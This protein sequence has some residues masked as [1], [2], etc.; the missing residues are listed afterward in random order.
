MAHPRGNCAEN[1]NA[2]L[3]P[4]AE[5]CAN[6]IM[7]STSTFVAVGNNNATATIT[8][9]SP[10]PSHEGNPES[11]T[12]RKRSP[13]KNQQSATATPIAS[14]LR[15]ISLSPTRII[16]N[17]NEQFEIKVCIE[18]CH[19]L[20]QYSLSRVTFDCDG[21]GLKRNTW[22]SYR[23]MNAVVQSEMLSKGLVLERPMMHTFRIQSSMLELVRYFN[24]K[25]NSILRVHL[26]TE[27]EVLGTSSIDLR[28]VISSEHAFHDDGNGFEG[29]MVQNDYTFN[30]RHANAT[31]VEGDGSASPLCAPRIAVRLCIDR[32]STIRDSGLNSDR[33]EMI[34]NNQRRSTASVSLSTSSQTSQIVCIDRASSPRP[35]TSHDENNFSF[36]HLERKANQLNSREV[37]LSNKEKELLRE[38]ASLERKRYE[39]EQWHH[40]EELEW[41]DMLR[42]KEAAM[43]KA[44][45]ERVHEIEME[46]KSSLESSKNEYD[47]LES[48]LR[49]ALIDVEAKE[50]QLK[51]VELNNQNERKSKLAELELREKLM[52][53]ELKHSIEI[54]VRFDK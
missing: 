19:D 41:K 44:I 54:E 29:R 17:G 33:P 3:F 24:E 45:E 13:T 18:Q 9:S 11:S 21:T 16:G 6:Q 8:T 35:S 34:A 38:V 43:L 36:E 42:Q 48:R 30:P 27:G 37:G 14:S 51:N 15:T 5:E 47:K 26:C 40:R 31:T 46:R 1:I 7:M 28:Q 20:D 4:T 49:K 52:K 25:K 10:P 32:D 53:E 22:L 2:P 12:M 23:F 39:W 50:R